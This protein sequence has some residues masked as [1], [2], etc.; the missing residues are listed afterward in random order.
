M[1]FPSFPFSFLVGREV[2]KVFPTRFINELPAQ[3]TKSWKEISGFEPSSRRALLQSAGQKGD[4]P[5]LNLGK[6]DP[7]IAHLPSIVERA[8]KSRQRQTLCDFL[9]RQ[10]PP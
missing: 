3:D 10:L 8:S 7:L 5:L 2:R 9:D 4:S 6:R 1:L